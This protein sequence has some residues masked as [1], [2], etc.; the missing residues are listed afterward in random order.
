MPVPASSRSKIPLRP[1]RSLPSRPPP[2]PAPRRRRSDVDASLAE[3]RRCAVRLR[4]HAR[5]GI[6]SRQRARVSVG[7]E[8]P[9][10]EGR[11]PDRRVR[12]QAVEPAPHRV[13][14]DHR[15]PR[16]GVSPCVP[17]LADPEQR[18]PEPAL[19]TL[20]LVSLLHSSTPRQHSSRKMSTTRC[21]RLSSRRS[22]VGGHLDDAVGEVKGLALLPFLLAGVQ[23]LGHGA[24][25]LVGRR[26]E[27]VPRLARGL[28]ELVGAG[29]VLLDLV[30]RLAQPQLVLVVP[31]RV[32]RLLPTAHSPQ[33]TAQRQHRPPWLAQRLVLRVSVFSSG[34][35]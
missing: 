21:K 12:R 33:P 23:A 29:G 34:L 2:A 35:Q 5:H 11:L 8:L 9:P 14:L 15:P 25:G 31:E 27:R 24:R 26:R 20:T 18:R 1:S 7:P 19:L 13:A 28:E 16:E 6:A 22:R 4:G 3:L 32:V 17:R 10:V 30:V